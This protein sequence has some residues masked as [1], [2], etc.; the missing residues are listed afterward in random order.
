MATRC[1]CSSLLWTCPPTSLRRPPTSLRRPG[2]AFEPRTLLR[3]AAAH[4][5]AV[6][7]RLGVNGLAVP[8]RHSYLDLPSSKLEEARCSLT[9]LLSLKKSGAAWRRPRTEWPRVACA[10]AFAASPGS[11]LEEARCSY[12]VSD[13]QTAACS[14]CQ[15]QK[16]VPGAFGGGLGVHGHAMP[17]QQPSLDIPSSELQEARCRC[18]ICLTRLWI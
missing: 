15:G 8:L 7:R 14:T 9:H 1:M 17:V 16:A 3:A 2:A 5:G 13:R 6:T 4:I 18:R 11:D 12:P 10:A